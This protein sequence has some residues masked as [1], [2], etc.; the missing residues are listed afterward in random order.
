MF[1]LLILSITSKVKQSKMVCTLLLT[2]PVEEC[3]EEII[4]FDEFVNKMRSYNELA[5]GAPWPQ[6][7]YEHNYKILV[8]NTFK[9]VHL[10]NAYEAI[11]VKLAD[12]IADNWN[13]GVPT[14]GVPTEGNV[15]ARMNA[16]FNET[17]F[18]DDIKNILLEGIDESVD[19]VESVDDDE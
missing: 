19:D 17:A 11:D 3:D 8:N 10:I 15:D 5:N 4:S 14:E 16:I 1:L 13:E 18:N 6:D 2:P 7:P 9:P 12:Y